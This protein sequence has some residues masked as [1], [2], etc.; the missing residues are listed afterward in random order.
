MLKHAPPEYVEDTARSHLW[1][2]QGQ[3]PMSGGD[4]RPAVVGGRPHRMRP[5]AIIEFSNLNEIRALLQHCYP[6]T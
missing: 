1:R 6:L 5:S 4:L 2:D 3:N